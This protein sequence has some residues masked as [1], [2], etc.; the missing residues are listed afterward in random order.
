[1]HAAFLAALFSGP[2]K[3]PAFLI[4]LG[5]AVWHAVLECSMAG[6]P[7]ARVSSEVCVTSSGSRGSPVSKLL[8][9]HSCFVVQFRALCVNLPLITSQC[10]VKFPL[11]LVDEVPL[12]QIPGFH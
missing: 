10:T 11:G 2:T 4:C 8:R 3:G 1:M 12:Y 7:E 5:W 6:I 9:M